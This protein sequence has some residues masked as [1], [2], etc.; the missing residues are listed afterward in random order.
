MDYYET[1]GVNH[2][3]LPDEIKKAYKKLA[4]KHHPDKG[5]DE[6]EFKK[7]Q[8]AYEV[9]G[10]PQKKQAYDN[11]SPFGQGSPFGGQQ[12]GMDDIFSQFFGNRRQ[13]QP[14]R[15]P[16]GVLDIQINLNEAY[17]GTEKVVDTGYAQFK[18]IIPMGSKHGTK[19]NMR[20]KGP[21]KFQGLPVGDLI[22][23]LHV[24]NPPEWETVNHNDLLI[25]V[26]IDYFESM[27]GTEVRL[28]HL[29]NKKIDVKVPKNSGP[30][31]SLRLS[32][33]GMPDPDNG[34]RG[35]LFV[36]LVVV[37]PKLDDKMLQDLERIYN[38]EK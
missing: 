21:E 6:A 29:D 32:G 12:G 19:F 27:L 37:P 36:E 1:L 24:Y 7:I 20:G 33:K 31:S 13:Q 17:T 30:G 2:T 15:N 26:Q 4:S 8:A 16:D 34:V 25:K 23:R 10:D 28:T 14:Q 18:L 22:V 11:P 3:T 9:L 35:N 38:K 5:G